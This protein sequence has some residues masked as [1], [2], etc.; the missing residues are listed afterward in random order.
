MGIQGMKNFGNGK[1]LQAFSAGDCLRYVLSLPISCTAIGCTTIGQLEDDVRFAQKFTPFAAEEMEALRRR[2]E[3]IKG[4][5]SR[6][7]KGTSRKRRAG[8]RVFLPPSRD[9]GDGKLSAL[10]RQLSARRVQRRGSPC[11][12]PSPAHTFGF[13]I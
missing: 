10:S 11:G 6:I 8:R 7:G 9:T 13:H 3:S 1:L 4:P 12:R 5:Y 2:A